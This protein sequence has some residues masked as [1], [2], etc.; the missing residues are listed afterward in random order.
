[1]NNP[2]RSWIPVSSFWSVKLCVWCL[3]C[4]GMGGGITFISEFMFLTQKCECVYIFK[5]LFP[6]PLN[7]FCFGYMWNLSVKPSL[8]LLLS[9]WFLTWLTHGF[10]CTLHG[11][12]LMMDSP[13]LAPWIFSARNGGVAELSPFFPLRPFNITHESC[14]SLVPSH[15]WYLLETFQCAEGCID[16]SSILSP[17]LHNSTCDVW[18]SGKC[19]TVCF[20]FSQKQAF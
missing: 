9:T 14:L 11:I 13:A 15:L 3:F 18:H 1:M 16:P 5:I 7:C 4:G 12:S 10:L 2:P 6:L 19:R 20:S 8:C 17:C